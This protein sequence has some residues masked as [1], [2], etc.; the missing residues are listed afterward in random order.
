MAWVALV[1]LLA[2]LIPI[3]VVALD[4]PIGRALRRRAE[5]PAPDQSAELGALARRVEQL[6]GEV[7][8][9]SR[10]VE[11]MREE[12]QSLQKVIEDAPLRSTLPP[13]RDP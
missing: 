6:E 9:L 3:G 12:N 11:V 10:A 2:L 4:T 8:D 7:D 5:P 13:R 1:L